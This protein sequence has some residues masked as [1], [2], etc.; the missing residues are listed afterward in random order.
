MSHASIGKFKKREI[1]ELTDGTHR[2]EKNLYIRVRANGKYRNYFFRYLD[3]SGK[4]RDMALGSA[5]KTPIIEVKQKAYFF[6]TL[7]SVAGQNPSDEI[8]RASCRERV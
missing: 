6:R 4:V 3:Q 1:F 5:S 7:L 8:G 2:L